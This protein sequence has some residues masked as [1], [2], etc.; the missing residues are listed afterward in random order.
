MYFFQAGLTE[1][2]RIDFNRSQLLFH[3]LFLSKA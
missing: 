1:D 3:N 2:N